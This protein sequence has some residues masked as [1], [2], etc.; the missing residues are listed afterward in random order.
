MGAATA[1][2]AAG[3]EPLVRGVVSDSA[4]ADVSALIVQETAGVGDLNLVYGSL[5]A[6]KAVLVWAYLSAMAITLGAQVAYTYRGVFGTNAEEI[7]LP[8]PK[9]RLFRRKRRKSLK[10]V[11]AT[12]GGWLLPPERE[13]E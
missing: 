6:L 4:F 13:P 5:G 10:S 1:L 9:R 7:A 3:D 12:M 11:L 2:L 8:K